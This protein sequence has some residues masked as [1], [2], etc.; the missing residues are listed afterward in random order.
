[1]PQRSRGR[2]I[3]QPGAA[4]AFGIRQAQQRYAEVIIPEGGFNIVALEM[5]VVW[6]EG[7]LRGR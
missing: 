7:M 5:V 6:I 3:P 1:M 2:P 4:Q